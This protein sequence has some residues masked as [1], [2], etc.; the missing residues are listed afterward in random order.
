M[1]YTGIGS[2]ETPKEVLDCFVRI[3][4]YLA[5]Q[6]WIL[7]SG[8]ASGA[9]S[10]FE[11]G[12]NMVPNGP[13]E[14]YLPWK[15]FNNNPSKLYNIPNDIEQQARLIAQ[16]VHPNWSK[17]SE[18]AKKMHTRNVHQILGYCLNK[19]A[20]VVICWTPNGS[21]SGGTGQ[22]LRIAKQYNIPIFD[23]GSYKELIDFRRE[24]FNF[25]KNIKETEK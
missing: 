25:I 17:C 5:E 2:R 9:D 18:G 3:G 20:D 19:P 10:A 14:I 13:K 16:Q 22:A 23:A 4:K 24:L 12:C 7:R 6:K 1:I 11:S 15:C 21:G 8:G